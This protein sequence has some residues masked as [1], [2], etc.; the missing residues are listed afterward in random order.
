MLIDPLASLATVE[1]FLWPRVQ[2]SDTAQKLSICVGNSESGNTCSGAA[3]SSPST[4]TPASPST[5]TPASDTRRHFSRSRSSVSIGD[6]V[7]KEPSS[8]E[9]STRSS[10]GKG[11]VVLEMAQE[12]LRGPQ[13]INAARRRAALGK[14]DPMKPVNGVSTSEVFFMFLIMNYNMAG[15]I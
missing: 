4:T 11:K 14:D 2:R 15:L 9:N 12:R 8:Q 3:T 5:T 7:R 1:D 6:A 10:K 13:T